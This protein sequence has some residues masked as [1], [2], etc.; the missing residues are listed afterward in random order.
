MVKRGDMKIKIFFIISFIIFSIFNINCK[1]SDP[2]P[3][4][5][6][7]IIYKS[8]KNIVYAFDAN[9]LN[10]KEI[11]LILNRQKIIE[12]VQEKIR[13]DEYIIY[14][15]PIWKTEVY[16]LNIP[17]IK[18]DQYYNIITDMKIKNELLKV[19]N[20]EKNFFYLDLLTGNIIN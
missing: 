10:K 7:N 17:L 8:H 1:L 11:I 3:I 16:K 13:D 15:E 19:T 9:K 18:L 5:H 4:L 2:T 12:P 14:L 6:N 20:S